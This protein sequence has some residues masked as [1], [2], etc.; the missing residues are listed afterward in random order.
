MLIPNVVLLK[1]V[2]MEQLPL[3]F[4]FIHL[5][6]VALRFGASFILCMYGVIFKNWVD[7]ETIKTDD[8]FEVWTN[9]GWR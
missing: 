4:C 1:R 3:S 5:P 9:K 8:E 6:F 2:A 7:V